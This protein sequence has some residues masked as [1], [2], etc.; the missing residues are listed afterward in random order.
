MRVWISLGSSDFKNREPSSSRLPH[1]LWYSTLPFSFQWRRSIARRRNRVQDRGEA[2]F[3]VVWPARAH[4]SLSELL[5]AL[6][7]PATLFLKAL[8]VVLPSA[9]CK[10]TQ[11]HPRRCPP[12][13]SSSL[14]FSGRWTFRCI[15]SSACSCGDLS[16]CGRQNCGALATQRLKD[17][18]GPKC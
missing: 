11:I 3:A 8:F 1:L 2:V 7:P 17:I 9:G 15:L 18:L 13:V 5:R 10:D 4:K 16:R 14:S 12:R 6:S